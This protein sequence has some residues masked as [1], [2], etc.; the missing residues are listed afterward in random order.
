MG[1]GL[2]YDF[3]RVLGGGLFSKKA[4]FSV[5]SSHNSFSKLRKSEKL[6]SYTIKIHLVPKNLKKNPKKWDFQKNVIEFGGGLLFPL[7]SLGGGG[8]LKRLVGEN[9]SS[10]IICSTYANVFQIF[11]DMFKLTLEKYKYE[12]MFI[13]KIT[14]YEQHC[15]Q[16]TSHNVQQILVL[17]A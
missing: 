8:L 6:V 1:G 10:S 2:F 4:V 14:E 17:I 11:F 15:V 13:R 7:T 12:R 3:S 9:I 16:S 5:F